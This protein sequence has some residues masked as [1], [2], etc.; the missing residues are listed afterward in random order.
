MTSENQG[1]DSL[2]DPWVDSM[3]VKAE[4][5]PS[6]YRIW[7]SS[8]RYFLAGNIERAELCQQLNYLVHNSYV[9]YTLDLEGEVNFG[10]GGIGLMALRS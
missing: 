1:W 2:V 7:L 9:P 10:Y 6:A 3:A 4:K 8:R 5:I